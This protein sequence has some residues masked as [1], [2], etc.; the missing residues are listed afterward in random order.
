[1]YLQSD[2]ISHS[3]MALLPSMGNSCVNNDHLRKYNAGFSKILAP[4]K[5]LRK[6][7]IFLVVTEDGLQNERPV[8]YS[9][10]TELLLLTDI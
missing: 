9:N 10:I 6:I 7:D 4:T 3:Y 8:S 2:S 1:M 5:V